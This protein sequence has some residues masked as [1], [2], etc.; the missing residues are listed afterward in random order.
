MY[1]MAWMM[2]VIFGVFDDLISPR[3]SAGD[4]AALRLHDR[5][6]TPPHAWEIG[7]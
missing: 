1:P 5:Q 4:R 7:T 6:P 2:P 3:S